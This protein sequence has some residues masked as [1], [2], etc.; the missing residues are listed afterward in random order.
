M[1]SAAPVAAVTFA[2]VASSTTTDTSPLAVVS[3][4]QAITVSDPTLLKTG[5]PFESKTC[6][7]TLASAGFSLS[8]IGTKVTSFSCGFDQSSISSRR[9]LVAVGN[10][11]FLLQVISAKKEFEVLFEELFEQEKD[12]AHEIMKHV[13]QKPHDW[14]ILN[15]DS[16][17][18]YKMFDEVIVRSPDDNTSDSDD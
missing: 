16:Q 14:L 12:Y 6:S 7:L 9:Q 5:S 4:K 11:L 8:D 13:Y 18:M 15:V 3:G 1:P 2:P 17:R 10:L